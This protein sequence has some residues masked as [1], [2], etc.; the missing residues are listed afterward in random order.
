MAVLHAQDLAKLA[1]NAGLHDT[2]KIAHAVAIAIA[3]SGGDPKKHNKNAATKDDSYGLWQINLYG[4]LKASRVGSNGI[5][6]PTSLYDP[7]VN[8]RAM[9]SISNGGKNWTPWGAYKNKTY[10][11]FMPE[12]KTAAADVVKQ[13]QGKDSGFKFSLGF[14]VS[15]ALG[16]LDTLNGSQLSAENLRSANMASVVNGIMQ[17]LYKGGMNV[18]LFAAGAVLLILAVIIMLRQPLKKAAVKIV[19]VAK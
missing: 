5:G 7:E 16:V 13:A 11:L 18:L 14:V 19:E 15:P 12:A 3:E 2:D 6:D 4:N 10:L 8:A 1:W 17:T 9:V